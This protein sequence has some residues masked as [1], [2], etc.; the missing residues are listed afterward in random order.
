ML[1]TGDA[2]RAGIHPRDLYALRDSGEL[3]PVSRGVFRLASLPPLDEPDLVTVSTRAPRAIIAAISALHFHG[4]TSEIPHTV[5]IALP[6]GI[7]R[8]RLDWPPLTV[9]WF[10]GPMYSEGIET[11]QRDG[12]NI[13]IYSPVKSVVDCFRL[14]NRLGIDVAVEALR[15][16]LDERRF[17]PGELIAMAKLCRVA[18]VVRPYLEAMQ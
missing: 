10:S 16:G 1:S 4:L 9:Y 8:P 2:L 5:S 6:K 11:H 14:R 3:E 17:T 13:R 7:K 18:G 15:T 12:I